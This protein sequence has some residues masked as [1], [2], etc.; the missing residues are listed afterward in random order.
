MGVVHLQGFASSEGYLVRVSSDQV[1]EELSRLR[2]ALA[3][4]RSQ[5]EE[6]KSK[7]GGSLGSNELRIFDTH[8]AYLSDPKF[9]EE[10]ETMVMDER[11]S[12]RSGIHKVVQ[13]YDRIVQL[14]END[15][16]RQRAGDLRDVATRVLRNLDDGAAAAA[17]DLPQG[18]YVL[19]AKKL[20]TTD[21]FGLDSERVE[22][23][24]AE[25]GGMSSHAAILARSMGIPTITGIRDLPSLVQNGT[26]VIVDGATGQL[27]V[28]PDERLRAEYQRTAEQTRGIEM[29]AGDRVH[30]TRD[31]VAV[32]LMAAC[33]SVGEATLA[34]TMAMDG[35][36]V[37]RTE[38]SFLTA[39]AVPSE[40]NL[41]QQYREVLHGSKGH[42]VTFRL[43]DVSS[44][45]RLISLPSE[46]E[47]NPAMGMRGIRALLHD[48]TILRL[49]LR[50]ILRACAGV[51]DAGVL[52]PF[53]TG[54]SELQRVKA[55]ILEER[56]ELRK[57]NIKCASVLRIAPIIEIPAAAFVLHAFLNE[58]DF[59]VVAID[60]LQAHLL[61][62]DR[63][64]TIVRDYY[65]TVHPALFELV[66]RMSRDAA[67]ADKTLILF[68]EGAADPM[69]VP[70]YIGVGVRD[71]SVAPVRLNGILKV[72]RRF[73]VNECQ[74]IAE[75]VLNAP[76]A[77][78]VQR[79]LV[80]L[81]QG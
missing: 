56:L 54:L 60:D 72:L 25:E 62:A 58:S 13:S 75:R 40:D 17:P 20:T 1:E 28:N 7:H 38:L 68:G 71:F 26:F 74:K 16:L 27:H 11:L 53:V 39:G 34:R 78:D 59:A 8:I 57:Q 5:I 30:E 3:K 79:V 24:V 63:D 33:G 22:G 48:G 64:N 35:I 76:R 52:V 44:S 32:R 23:I 14:V 6:L 18:G 67:K 10:I 42:P 31:G 46:T 50:A 36:G 51:D 12:V 66:A 4:S 69:R 43:L 70:F 29:P 80:R 21:M 2:E 65:E 9:V 47:R 37:Y 81:S 55:A 61:A 77:L 73:T 41:V 15:Y 19:A 49:Q 45:T